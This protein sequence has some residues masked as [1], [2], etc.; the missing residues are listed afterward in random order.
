MRFV[1]E[2]FWPLLAS[3]FVLFVVTSIIMGRLSKRFFTVGKVR[4]SFSI[5]DLEFPSK[6][7]ELMKLLQGMDDLP[8]QDQARDA[9]AA[10][11]AHLG[12]DFLFM[13][14]IYPL[15]FLLCWK[16]SMKMEWTGKGLFMVLAWAQ[17]LP[18]LFDL[19]E[20]IYL[21]RKVANPETSSNAV[22]KMYLRI[23]IG[24]WLIALTGL[25]CAGSG[26]L[27]FWMTGAYS[28][29]SLPWIGGLLVVFVLGLVVMRVAGGKSKQ[30]AAS[31][32][33]GVAAAQLES[34]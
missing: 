24:K 9:K 33:G 34:R 15:I 16:T 25:I 29:A 20:N 6:S 10:L 2:A 3:S 17:I 23:V 27:Y 19:A 8:T 18:L 31:N 28:A 22:H 5:F 11:R 30:G 26:L 14:G 13:L 32:L 21:L 7:S 12:W 1:E 4:Q